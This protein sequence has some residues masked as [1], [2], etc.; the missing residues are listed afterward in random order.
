MIFIINRVAKNLELEN[1]G[2]NNLEFEKFSTLTST[3]SNFILKGAK[4]KY[5]LTF[6]NEWF[7]YK[8]SN[9]N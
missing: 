2:K 1:L 8:F 5:K 7:V 6:K 9:E 4:R 3:F